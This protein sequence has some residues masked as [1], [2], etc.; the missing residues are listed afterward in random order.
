MLSVC[1]VP[2]LKC[3]GSEEPLRVIQPEQNGAEMGTALSSRPP[4]SDGEG[5][6]MD[7]EVGQRRV[8]TER[9]VR[10]S[11]KVEDEE[12]KRNWMSR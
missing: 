9:E 6:A 4:T 7:L 2:L 1:L 5:G 12:G 11:R 10:T 3:L 8:G